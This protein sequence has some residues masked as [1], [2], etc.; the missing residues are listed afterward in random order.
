MITTI[1]LACVA[2]SQGCATYVPAKQDKPFVEQVQVGDR[3]RVVTVD[4][5]RREF[6]VTMVDTNGLY[7]EGVFIR[8]DEISDI[9]MR[10]IPAAT[11]AM[12]VLGVIL[13]LDALGVGDA[14]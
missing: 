3:V 7:D 10:K 11:V 2:L 1:A 12:T 8:F 5:D 4:G 14:D 13:V 6:I 9:E